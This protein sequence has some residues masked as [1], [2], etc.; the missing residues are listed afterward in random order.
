VLLAAAETARGRVALAEQDASACPTLRSAVRHWRALDVPYEV[1]TAR[2]LLGRACE[3][4]GDV[5]GAA[6][7]YDAAHRLFSDL[8]AVVD[9]AAV[10]RPSRRGQLPCGLSEREAEVLRLVAAGHT[11]KQIAAELSLS[12]KTVAR[13]LS[14]IFTKI[15]VSSR[16]GA[17]AFAFEH[18]LVAR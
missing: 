1:A 13:H 3:A 17:T 7:S 12:D 2:V 18:H 15:D 14:N 8:G 5:D 10:P 9:A 16:T 6:A 4:A 11:N